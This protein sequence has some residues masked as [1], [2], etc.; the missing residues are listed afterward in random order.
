MSINIKNKRATFN[1][2]IVDQFTAGIQLMGSE[3]K[4]I[5]AG[6]ASMS[7][8]YC[9]IKKGELF[10]KN[11]HIAEYKQASYTG[12]KDPV[13][14]RKLLLNKKELSKIEKKIK[15]KGMA[16]V[17]VKMFLSARGLLKVEIG[18]A[19]GKKIHDK[20]DSIKDRDA[21]RQLDR[22]KGGRA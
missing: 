13:R 2:E 15:E 11:M 4:S 3:V 20:R 16:V 5:R 7:E 8:S 22:F 12:H 19:K 10:I 17:P 1:Y 9:Y 21:K 6:K 18:L 14:E